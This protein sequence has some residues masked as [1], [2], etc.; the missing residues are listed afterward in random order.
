M[1]KNLSANARDAGSI[2]GSGRHDQQ[3]MCPGDVWLG[4]AFRQA[5]VFRVGTDDSQEGNQGDEWCGQGQAQ[6]GIQVSAG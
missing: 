2:P 5:C 6:P 4:E 3:V 1:V